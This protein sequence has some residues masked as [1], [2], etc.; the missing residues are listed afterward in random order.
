M[1]TFAL[2]KTNRLYWLGRYVERAYLGIQV[3]EKAY[4]ESIDGEP[5]DY[6]TYCARLNIPNCYTDVQDFLFRYL[7]DTSN[8]DS[9]VTA[10]NRAFDNAVVL[11][12]T[13]GSMALS[14]IQMAKNTMELAATSTAP[15]LDLQDVFD[16]I[17]AFKGCV[18]DFV[19]DEANRMIVKL[20]V[21]IEHI[22]MSL[23]LELDLDQLNAH[24]ARLE[25][26]MRRSGMPRDAKYVR[27][28][29]NLTPCPN[30]AENK[31]ILLEC[32]ENLFPG[33]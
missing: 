31:E 3:M 15:M 1:G 23:R 16:Y 9:T 26:R 29:N 17:M 30:P 32:V 5:F 28:L 10:L 7:Y 8:P 19:N 6:A 33:I 22:D 18:D 12:E 24:F 4:D 2:S 20:G 27:L 21:S 11:R 14:Y 25:S 13:I